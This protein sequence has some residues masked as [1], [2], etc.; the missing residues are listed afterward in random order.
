MK[1]TVLKKRI[2]V[3]LV[4]LGL[5]TFAGFAFGSPVELN[6]V[7]RITSAD[8]DTYIK[9]LTDAFNQMNAG[10]IHLNVTGIADKIYKSKIELQLAGA[11]LRMS[12]SHGREDMRKA[13]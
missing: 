13:W 3:L 8:H 6:Y 9:W 2:V 5:I 1:G 11:G 7:Y 10:K 4:F 12:S